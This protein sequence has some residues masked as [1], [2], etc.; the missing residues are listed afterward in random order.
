MGTARF[1]R[2][3]LFVLPGLTAL[4]LIIGVP[5]VTAFRYSLHEVFLYRFGNQVFVGLQNYRDLWNDPLFFLS[6]RTTL[7]FTIGNT[8]VVVVM[9]LLVAFLLSSKKVRFKTG[10]MALFL[11]P[12]VMTQVVVGLTFRLFVWEP[13][14]GVINAM[15]GVLGFAPIGWLIDRNWAMFATVLTNSWHLTPLALLVFYAALTTIPEELTDSARIDGA[16][17]LQV[18][19]HVILPMIR[20][21]VLFVSLI[22]MTSAFREFELVFTLTGGGPGRTTSVLSILA[23]NRGIAN[24]DMGMANTIAFTMFIIMATV[25]WTYIAIF[26]AQNRRGEDR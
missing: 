4:V 3:W 9:G 6:L 26:R 13:E 24:S 18:L 21:H 23:Y 7:V 19:W 12:F 10:F 16:G 22:I 14:Y 1:T 25:A 5:L 17:P 15:L 2:G 8:A 11:L 20:S